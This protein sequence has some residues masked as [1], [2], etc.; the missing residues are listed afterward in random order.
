M[1][2]GLEDCQAFIERLD[3]TDHDWPQALVDYQAL[4]L[5]DGEAVVTLAE[6]HFDELAIAARDPRYVTRKRLEE[7]L[8]ELAPDRFVPLYTRVAFDCQ[9]YSE[10]LRIRHLQEELLDRLMAEPGIE[11]RL[12]D[13][14]LRA[15]LETELERFDRPTRDVSKGPPSGFA[16]RGTEAASA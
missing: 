16:V 5:E 10:I 12:D 14:S 11:R 8:H 15:R 4:R 2:A 1:N 3:A 6:Q 13:D 9:P 7:K